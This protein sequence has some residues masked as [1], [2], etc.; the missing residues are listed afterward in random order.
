MIRAAR[1][2]MA[3]L[4]V[5]GSLSL[6]LLAA[7]WQALHDPH[8]H[9]FYRFFAW[10]ALLGIILLNASAWFRDPTSP[11]QIISWLMLFV[12]LI[13]AIN[14]FW[15][16]K[17]AGRAVGGIEN[18]TRLITEGVFRLIRHPLYAS[19]L[20]LGWGAFFKQPSLPAAVLVVAASL[21]LLVTARVEETEL[22][23]RFGPAYAEYRRQSRMFIP[24]LF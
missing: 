13:L 19:L 10:E 2:M 21:L 24:Y 7:S 22:L 18:T 8:S 23:T 15:M 14:G 5:F 16:L 17:T 9:G 20:F 12:S 11:F 3:Q 4:A 6:I 1:K